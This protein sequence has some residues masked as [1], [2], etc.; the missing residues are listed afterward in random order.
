MC[1]RRITLD[2]YQTIDSIK[3]EKIPKVLDNREK[4]KICIVEDDKTFTN[5]GFDKLGYKNVSIH[6]EALNISNY[7]DFDIILCDIKG[8]A[9]EF[10]DEQGL[11]FAKELKKVYPMCEIYI[12]TGQNV[13]NYGATDDIPVIHKPKSKTELAEYFDQSV[14]RMLSPKCIWDKLY[15]YLT[16]NKISAKEIV[17]IEDSF[18]KSVRDNAEFKPNVDSSLQ[19][20]LDTASRLL[21]IFAAAAAKELC[22]Q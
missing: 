21:G 3:G 1:R 15:I 7:K 14:A 9:N 13:K 8:I 6:R 10:S 16:S 18:V 4:V 2:L 20:V 17:K 5:E 12:Y 11:A 19:T 22:N